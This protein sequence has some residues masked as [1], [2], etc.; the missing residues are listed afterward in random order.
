MTQT[1]QIDNY[2]GFEDGIDGFTLAEKMQEALQNGDEDMVFTLFHT[3]LN[4]LRTGRKNGFANYDFIFSNILMDG[5]KW[6]V[7]DYEWTMNRD[8]PAEELAF[9]AAYCFSLE[10][11]A[12][13]FADICQILDFDK[14]DVQVLIEKET[15]YQRRITGGQHFV[16]QRVVTYTQVHRCCGL[17]NWLQRTIEYRFMKTADMVFRRKSPTLWSMY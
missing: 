6:Q 10:H 9:R 13:P 3:F 14:K 16:R 1:S 4:K 11:S 8:V 12:F 15:A 2:P 5:D 7:I 17:W